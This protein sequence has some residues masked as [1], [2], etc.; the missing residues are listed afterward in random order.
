MNTA[1]SLRPVYTVEQFCAEILC[2]TR[3]PEW[4]RDQIAAR[5]IKA[6]TSRPY[7]ISAGEVARFLQIPKTP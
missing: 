2:N 3:K 1:P 6:I 5:R 4:V 7:L